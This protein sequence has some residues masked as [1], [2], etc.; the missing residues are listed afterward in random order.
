MTRRYEDT[1]EYN[2]EDWELQIHTESDEIRR[3]WGLSQQLRTE[4]AAAKR[5]PNTITTEQVNQILQGERDRRWTEFHNRR[6][7]QEQ[8]EA[9]NT[10]RGEAAEARLALSQAATTTATTTRDQARAETTPQL[11]IPKPQKL[12][13]IVIE[14]NLLQNRPPTPIPPLEEIE[15]VT[16]DEEGLEEW[17]LPGRRSM[18]VEDM[19]RDIGATLAHKRPEVPN[20]TE[21]A[22]ERSKSP[23]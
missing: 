9:A 3:V 2:P 12:H 17:E 19:A 23:P 5:P 6:L 1:D 10:L 15:E 11:V 13:S 18:S 20:K 8:Q 22:K 21:L 7:A 4:A 16:E 14:N